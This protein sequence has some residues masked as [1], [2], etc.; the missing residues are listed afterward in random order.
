MI[1]NPPTGKCVK[2]AGKIGKQILKQAQSQ[3]HDSPQRMK[4][5]KKSQ[6]QSQQPKTPTMDSHSHSHSHSSKDD[7][8]FF[9]SKSASVR[10][11]KGVNEVVHDPALYTALGNDFRKVL[12]TYNTIEHVFQAEKIALVDRASAFKFTL[13]SGHEIGKGDGAMAQKN[14]KLVKLDATELGEWSRIKDGVMAAA[15]ASKYEQCGEAQAV[16]K[17]T[18]GAQLWHVV[19]RARPVRFVHLEEIR[20]RL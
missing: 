6:S 14:R 2:I 15:A 20:A 19:P 17:A 13:D 10:P 7:K 18:L 1:I 16:L 11:G 8:L 9:F 4:K 5:V 3:I 12:S